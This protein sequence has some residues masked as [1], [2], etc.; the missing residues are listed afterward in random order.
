M[1]Y[2][3]DAKW[4]SAMNGMIGVMSSALAARGQKFGC[5]RGLSREEAG[6][7]A[8]IALDS[9]GNPPDVV[10]EEGGFCVRYG[11]GDVQFYD[12]ADWKR[13]VDVVAA[14]RRSKVCVVSHADIRPN[15]SGTDNLGNP[16]IFWDAL[17]FALGSYSLGRNHVDDNSYFG[18][19]VVDY[20]SLPW[21][22]E[23]DS[24]DGGNLDLGGALGTYRIVQTSGLNIYWRAFERGYV[25]VNPTFK[26]A[27][28]ISL[29]ESCK[30]VTHSSLKSDLA[31]TPDTNT[32]NLNAHRAVFLY[33]SSKVFQQPTNP[34]EQLR[35]LSSQ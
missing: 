19:S 12:E 33:K 5:N 27:S 14:T 18:F 31:T 30:E 32:I 8:W 3:T 1:L 20:N 2:D 34:P 22:D 16:L 4:A 24:M 10:L 7:N 6:Y 28:G 17:W 13:I 29:P 23:Y 26:N 9:A 35:I 11:N 25:Y 15:E 21:F